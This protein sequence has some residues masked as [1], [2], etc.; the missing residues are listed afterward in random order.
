[1]ALSPQDA[2]KNSM[3]YTPDALLF[4]RVEDCI[5]NIMSDRE[6][7]S[8]ANPLRYIINI[9][10]Y[11]FIE[12]NQVVKILPENNEKFYISL[13][14]RI[15]NEYQNKGWKVDVV[16]KTFT[17]SEPNPAPKPKYP[18]CQWEH[19]YPNVSKSYTYYTLKFTPITK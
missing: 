6:W 9:C 4:K 11:N 19:W 10:P 8:E 17:R 2:L 3:S 13:I 16:D 12:L 1:M 5:D 7:V 15:V 18:E 14:A